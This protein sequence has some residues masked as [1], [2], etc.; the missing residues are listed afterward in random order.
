MEPW[1][2]GVLR[3]GY[4]IPFSSPPPLSWVPPRIPSYSPDFIGEGASRGG[5][6][7]RGEG[8]CRARSPLSVLLQPSYRSLEGNGFME[9]SNRPFTSELLRLT[10]EVQDGGQPVDSLC[11]TEE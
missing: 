1:V 6:F 4:R 11:N 10:N 7:P 2:V 5:S 8:S 3:T 9:T